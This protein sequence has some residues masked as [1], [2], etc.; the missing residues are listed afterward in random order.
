[1]TDKPVRPE[2]DALSVVREIIRR[3]GHEIRNALNGISVNVE[4][5][6]SRKAREGAAGEVSSFAERAAL[7]VGKAS[8]FTSGVLALVDAVLI[9]ASKGTLKSSRHGGASEIELMIYGDRAPAFVSDIAPIAGEIGM[10]VEQR[11]Q[12]VILRVLPEDK[13]HSQD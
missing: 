10:R 3:S 12:S 9:A 8:S 13:S 1:M 2:V 11:G 7:D 5:V 4:V 6:K